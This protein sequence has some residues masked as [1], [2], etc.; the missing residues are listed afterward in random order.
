MRKDLCFCGEIYPQMHN[1]RI[2]LVMNSNEQYKPS[3]TARLLKMALPNTEI[4]V[5]GAR[6]GFPDLPELRDP[7]A[8]ARVLFPGP[9]AELLDS[10]F[11]SALK[12]PLTLVVPDG[13][14][15][16]AKRLASHRALPLRHLK[17]VQL[18][19]LSSSQYQLRKAPNETGLCTAEA[20]A[21]ALGILES[22]ELQIHV[23]R[24]LALLVERVLWSRRTGQLFEREQ[25]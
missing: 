11:V 18:E 3:S 6:E 4:A 7:A 1:T 10:S 22:K 19:P 15:Q 9:D 12:S 16:Q 23:E 13:T 8:N 14:W 2:L 5:A 21:R 25:I 24:S 20:V 17:R